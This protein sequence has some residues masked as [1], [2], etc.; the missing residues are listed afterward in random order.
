[1]GKNGHQGNQAYLNFHV[2]F[3]AANSDPILTYACFG[4]PSSRNVRFQRPSTG[5]EN[6]ANC[7]TQDTY[8]TQHLSALGL[9]IL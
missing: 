3:L 2:E 8:E 4:L 9:G 6:G 5:V 1:M 7:N